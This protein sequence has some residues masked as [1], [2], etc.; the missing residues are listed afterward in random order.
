MHGITPT[1]A[2]GKIENLPEGKCLLMILCRHRGDEEIEYD[3]K[4][5]E[6]FERARKKFEAAQ[7]GKRK[8]IGMKVPGK[9]Q[10]PEVTLRLDPGAKGHVMTT[11]I[12]GG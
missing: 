12:S 2:I 8:M 11:P 3:P 10:K 6:S 9:G 7:Q 4:D 1:S 5:K